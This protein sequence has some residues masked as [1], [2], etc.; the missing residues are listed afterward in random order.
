MDN[1]ELRDRLKKLLAKDYPAMKA[2]FDVQAPIEIIDGVMMTT[3]CEAHNCAS[4][5]YLL[6]VDLRSDNINVFHVGDEGTEHY[7]ESGEI[8]LP[9][10]FAD[11]LTTE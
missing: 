4:N 1:A 3:G 2:N 9:K 8:K 5:Q 11:R 7:F 10:K 6:F